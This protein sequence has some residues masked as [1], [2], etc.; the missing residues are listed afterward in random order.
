METIGM[1]ASELRLGDKVAIVED[2]LDGA[3]WAAHTVSL[4]T[5][6]HATHGLRIELRT[7]QVLKAIMYR[8]ADEIVPVAALNFEAEE[9]AS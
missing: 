7:Q 5:L 1:F 9:V 8:G 2:G 4:I 3:Y 6:D